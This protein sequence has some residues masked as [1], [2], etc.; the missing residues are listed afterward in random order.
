MRL[1]GVDDGL[2]EGVLGCPFDTGGETQE[3]VTVEVVERDDL[4][5]RGA[6]LGQGAGLVDHE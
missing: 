1:G 4:G 5:D 3:L 6:S 2:G